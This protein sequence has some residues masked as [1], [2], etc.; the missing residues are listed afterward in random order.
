MVSK[1]LAAVAEDP[2]PALDPTSNWVL[3]KPW[4]RF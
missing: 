4:P 2:D 3:S 1:C